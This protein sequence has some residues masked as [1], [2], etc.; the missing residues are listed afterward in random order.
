MTLH[1]IKLSVGSDSL[2]DLLSWQ[3]GR[4]AETGNDYLTHITRMM[5]KR[6]QD[7]L[8]GGSIYWVVKGQSAM[9]QRILD[10][11][12]TERNGVPYCTIV[13]DP[14]PFPVVR[15]AHRPFQGWRYLDPKAAPADLPREALGIEPALR[16]RLMELGLL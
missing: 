8:D 3:A 9:R 16:D 1:L 11:K 13:Y 7:V 14:E 2:E 6:K 5:P 15:R 12:A 10:L 4:V